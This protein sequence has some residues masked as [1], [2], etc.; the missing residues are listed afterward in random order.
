MIFRPG[1]GSSGAT[2]V[3]LLILLL[4]VASIKICFFGGGEV[5]GRGMKFGEQRPESGGGILGR[6]QGTASPVP[7]RHHRGS[8]ERC[9][10]PQWGPGGASEKL[11]FCAT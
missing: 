7:T 9:K 8:G 10:L 6:G 3:V 11:K 5:T 2:N 4:P 1:N